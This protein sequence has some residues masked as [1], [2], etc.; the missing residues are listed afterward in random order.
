VHTGRV[1][2][3]GYIRVSRVAGREGDSFIS[4]QTQR[5]KIAQWAKLRDVEIAEWH[6][7]L[8][9]SGG[10]LKRPGLDALMARIRSGKTDG[11]AVA[12]LDRLSRAGVADALNLVGEI[13]K[14]GGQL[15]AVDLGIDPTTPFGEFSLTLMLGL[16]RME[17]RRISD[18]WEISRKRAVA[19]GVH[20]ASRTPTGYQRRKDKRLEPHPEYGPVV[21]ELFRLRAGGVGWRGLADHM[22]EAGVVGPY[23][24]PH[25]ETRAMQHILGNRVYLGEARSGAFV[26]AEGHEPLIDPETWE[27]AQKVNGNQTARSDNV[28]AVLAG[29]LRCQ[30]CRYVLKPDSMRDRD[31]TQLRM[32]RCRG[33]H[34]S[35]ICP[36]P[37]SVLER[38]VLP[39]IE[40]RFFEV[41]GDIQASG[42]VESEDLEN[43]Q[44]E[45]Q[46]AEAEVVAYR[47]NERIV[48][49]L[50]VDRYVEGLEQRVGTA[51]KAQEALAE[52]QM[53]TG[54]VP[55]TTSL[56]ESWGDLDTLQRRALFSAAFDAIFI[57]RGRGINIRD[58]L[59][60]FRRGDGP[61]DL[62]G[63][64][65][66]GME[67]RSLPWPVDAPDESGVALRKDP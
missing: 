10:V 19:R 31:G 66:R 40:Q 39:E 53:L 35:G 63:P 51:R 37:S 41:A 62:P 30:G 7:D 28:P 12:K 43:M 38:V 48:D 14:H 3:D 18:E 16:G 65:K 23:G 2:L 47:D 44:R 57:R 9:E 64:G 36:A 8:D 33:Q 50:G 49:A 60:F 46:R 45:L 55:M 20:I 22:N 5:E 27:A 15:A 67:L 59:L 13:S 61:G 29:L 54:G 25:W 1:P 11:V 56:W 52:A 24:S 4:P 21:S 58:R 34:A 17:R 32:Y 26:N 42:A 6:T